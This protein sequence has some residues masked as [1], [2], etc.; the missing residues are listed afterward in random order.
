MDS[1]QD[2][3]GDHTQAAD[4]RGPSL[5]ASSAEPAAESETDRWHSVTAAEVRKCLH[6]PTE[7]D[8]KYTRGV[9][10]LATGS[11][12]YPGAAVLSAQAACRAGAG[13]VRYTGPAS[14][15]AA[16]LAVRPEVVHGFGRFG[17]LV[18]GSGVPDARE[19]ER[20]SLYRSALAA[21]TPIVADAGALPLVEPGHRNL[22]ITPHA[23]ELSD[24]LKRLGLAKLT[25][26]EITEAH[27]EVAEFAAEQ[28]GCTVLLKGRHTHVIDGDLRFQVRTPNSWL[29]TAGTGDVLAG[30]IGALL[31]ARHEQGECEERGN[32]R[33]VAAAAWL[34]ARAGWLASQRAA[35]VETPVTSVHAPA[36]MLDHGPLGGPILASDVAIAI[37]NVIAAV[38]A[39]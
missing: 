29:A 21:G 19:D 25:A 20:A 23:R 27:G 4:D 35:G 10:L 1:T 11:V 17:A 14:V 18:I 16:V 32:G 26:T 28:L 30:V 6:I 3:V 8:N 31:A 37:P 2:A 5:G 7:N 39:K 33:V 15:A 22:V 38:L 13:M 12:T 36:L 9:V 24:L 34:H